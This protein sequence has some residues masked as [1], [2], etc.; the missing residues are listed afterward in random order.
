MVIGV[1]M[2]THHLRNDASFAIP[3]PNLCVL[4]FRYGRLLLV[5]S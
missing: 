5:E 1:R 4:R 3:M 2:L